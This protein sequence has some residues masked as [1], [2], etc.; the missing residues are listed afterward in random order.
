[1]GIHLAPERL[2]VESFFGRHSNLKYRAFLKNLRSARFSPKS[3][4]G[5]KKPS[6]CEHAGREA[7][8]PVYS[9]TTSGTSNQ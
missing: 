6:V 5:T 7:D 8:N 4:E 2:K 1:M 9:S 3:V